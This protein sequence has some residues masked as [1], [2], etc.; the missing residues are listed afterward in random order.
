MEQHQREQIKRREITERR[1][2]GRGIQGLTRVNM[3]KGKK[4]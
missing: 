4:N 1:C 2:V 3:C